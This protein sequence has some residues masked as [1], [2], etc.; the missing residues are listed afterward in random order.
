MLWHLCRCQRSLPSPGKDGCVLDQQLIHE[1][2]SIAPFVMFPSPSLVRNRDLTECESFAPMHPNTDSDGDGFPE[3][4]EDTSP[5][6]VSSSFAP[7]SA[8]PV[9]HHSSPVE[10]TVSLHN[11]GS[12]TSPPRPNSSPGLGELA[13]TSG[14]SSAERIAKAEA[15]RHAF[16]PQNLEEKA[17]VPGTATRG[18]ATLSE[19]FMMSGETVVSV[20]AARQ[21]AFEAQ[22]EEEEAQ[23]DSKEAEVEKNRETGKQEDEADVMCEE[24]RPKEEEEE[25]QQRRQV[26][27][28]GQ[29][30]VVEGDAEGVEDGQDLNQ[31]SSAEEENRGTGVEGK[32]NPAASGRLCGDSPSSPP[33]CSEANEDT[34][35]GRPSFAGAVKQGDNVGVSSMSY[36][37][38]SDEEGAFGGLGSN[39][40][41]E[42]MQTAVAGGDGNFSPGSPL[43]PDSFPSSAS[44]G[45]AQEERFSRAHTPVTEKPGLSIVVS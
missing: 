36:L 15:L 27:M 8:P 9:S 29:S 34:D 41:K 11:S 31:Q 13:S 6:G 32:D 23:E 10:G 3:S 39:M 17:R 40:A 16:S 19:S 24:E 7:P 35:A 18:S 45:S 20:N 5:M 43:S 26:G 22:E 42:F 21:L 28:E 12:F 38:Q 14:G 2:H 25:V 4:D 44:F 1:S 33:L 30:A 37:S